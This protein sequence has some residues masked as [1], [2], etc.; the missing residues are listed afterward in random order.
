MQITFIGGGNMAGAIIGGLLNQGYSAEA[1]RVV[2]IA[3]D[4]RAKIARQYG[5]DAVAQIDGA[6]V[7]GDCVVLA[8]KP[9]NM[10]EVATA[11]RPLLKHQ[12]VI[13]IAAG[14]R[15]T[16]LSRW[17]GGYPRLVRVMPNTPALVGAGCTGVYAAPGVMQEDVARAE[18]ILG[19]VGTTLRIEREEQLDAITAVSGSGPAYVFYFMEALQHAALDLGLAPDA[20]R[21]L[22]LATFVGAVKLAADSTEEPAILRARVTSKGGTTAAALASMDAA[23][24]DKSIRRAVKAADERSRELGDELGKD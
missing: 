23:G 24:I 20:A 11:L 17:L 8:V 5:I 21:R 10:R 1:L 15:S 13:S 2:E 14:I 19:A 6:A 18:A 7:A 12:L 4:A 9:Q 22:A 16:D 3:A